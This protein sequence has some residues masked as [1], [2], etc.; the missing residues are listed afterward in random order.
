MK[1][2]QTI[3]SPSAKFPPKFKRPTDPAPLFAMV[4]SSL[5]AA[6][7]DRAVI[8]S[9]ARP[10]LNTVTELKNPVSRALERSRELV[11]DPEIW[12]AS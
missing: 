2:I 1:Y 4:Y 11:E 10:F 3:A 9:R 5:L 6:E 12:K 8:L 7:S